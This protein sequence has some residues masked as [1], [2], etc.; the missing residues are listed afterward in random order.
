ML[1]GWFRDLQ[2]LHSLQE[3]AMTVCLTLN[4]PDR[5][6]TLQP[7]LPRGTVTLRRSQEIHRRRREGGKK[8]RIGERERNGN[9]KKVVDAGPHYS[10][11]IKATSQQSEQ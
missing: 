1:G 3:L 5:L 2:P 11:D 7:G 6:L 4:G 10:Q 9:R 8:A